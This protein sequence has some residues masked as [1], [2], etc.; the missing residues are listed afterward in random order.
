MINKFLYSKVL[1]GCVFLLCVHS[2][3][4]AQ[5]KDYAVEVSM[6]TKPVTLVDK[7]FSPMAYGGFTFAV[8]AGYMVTTPQYFD[9]T[10]FSY[11]TGNVESVTG[12]VI[13]NSK[14]L[15]QELSLDWRHVRTLFVLPEQD[16]SLYL[17]GDLFSSYTWYNRA[18]DDDIYYF[19]QNTLGPMLRMKKGLT[20]RGRS[21]VIESSLGFSLI[22][23]AVFPSY[24]T[25]LPPS[26]IEKDLYSIETFDFITSGKFLFP[27]KLQ[28]ATVDFSIG[29]PLQT[30]VV[31]KIG[32]S[33]S[34]LHYQR[35]DSCFFIH[36]S[37][38]L[39]LDIG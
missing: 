24:G 37:I 26:L 38:F 22:S 5:N 39:S 15:F 29:V 36:H 8:N 20:I 7:S 10:M 16:F 1:I 4:Y 9:S 17:G 6:G 34:V 25:S 21:A 27:D 18:Y 30:G 35:P 12:N 31:S 23:Y 2:G 33:W 3:A 28:R 19:Y 32:Y 13:S 11:S 14:A